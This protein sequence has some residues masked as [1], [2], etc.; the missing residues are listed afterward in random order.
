VTALDTVNFDPTDNRINVSFF[1]STG[2]Q[3]GGTSVAVETR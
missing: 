1:D 2:T 3:R